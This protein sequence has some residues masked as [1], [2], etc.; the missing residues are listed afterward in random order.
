MKRNV[1]GR[2]RYLAALWVG[3]GIA[4]A[5]IT[6]LCLLLDIESGATTF[7]YLI[8]IVLLSLMGSLVSSA[9]F[10]AVAVLCL[11]C[12]FTEPRHSLDIASTGDVITLAAFL[13]TALTITTLVRRVRRLADSHREQARLLDLTHDSILA[14]DMDGLVTYWNRGAEELYGWKRE[15][16]VGQGARKLLQTVLPIPLREIMQILRDTG[17][18]AGEILHTRRDGTQLTIASR[19][20]LQRDEAGNPTGMLE[21]N[22]DMTG[23]KRAEEAVRRAQETYLTEAQQLSHTGSFGWNVATGEIFWSEESFRIFGYEPN[24]TP[25]IDMVLRRVHPDDLTAVRQTIDR[26]AADQQDFECEHRVLLP[27]GTVRHLHVVGR[28]VQDE[29][30]KLHFM[31]ALHGHHGAP[32]NRGR[33]AGQRAA[34][35]AALSLH[36]RRPP[37]HRHPR[38]GGAARDFRYHQRAGF[39][40]AVAA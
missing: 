8:A 36:A 2:F 18:W 14:C 21:A 33:A 4:L 6:W 3:G 26:A 38:F 1:T 32:Q 30:G 40:G 10:S 25:S 20:S 7:V 28:A 22:T 31:G 37:A 9:L 19:W 16:A 5:A 15:E 35:P 23:R 13:I 11:N 17:L 27:D 39:G 12:F 24:L 34:I 29:P